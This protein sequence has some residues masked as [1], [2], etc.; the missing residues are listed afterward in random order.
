MAGYKTRRD[1]SNW[2]S[3]WTVAKKWTFSVRSC[4]KI[5]NMQSL[6]YMWTMYN[7]CCS[8]VDTWYVG[9]PLMARLQSLLSFLFTASLIS[10]CLICSPDLGIKEVY[11]GCANDKFG[12]CGS[13]LSLHCSSSKLPNRY[14]SMY[15]ISVSSW[16]FISG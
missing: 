2:C 9:S 13:I 7:V 8:F 6:C 4:W 11:Y 1:G 10:Y 3:S 16:S 14:I 15:H 5:F 12:G